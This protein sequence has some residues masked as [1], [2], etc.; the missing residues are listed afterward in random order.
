MKRRHGINTSRTTRVKTTPPSMIVPSATAGEGPI[1]GDAPPFYEDSISAPPED[2][3]DRSQSNNQQ[4]YPP[5]IN[6][7]MT[8]PMPATYHMA[9]HPNTMLSFYNLTQIQTLDPNASVG[10]VNIST[11]IDVIHAI[12]QQIVHH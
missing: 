10:T 8:T 7:A 9:S 11:P 2:L 5:S 6:V 12:P 4:F 3:S 1:T